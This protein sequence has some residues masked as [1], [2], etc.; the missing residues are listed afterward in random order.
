MPSGSGI[1]A[2][3]STTAMVKEVLMS[4]LR[5]SEGLN[6]DAISVSKVEYFAKDND[7]YVDETESMKRKQK[8]SVISRLAYLQTSRQA[9]YAS[10]LLLLY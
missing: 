3:Y 5:G 9:I 6:V 10:M 4:R 2:A 1:V 8:R 7:G